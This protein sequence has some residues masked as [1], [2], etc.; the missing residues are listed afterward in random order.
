MADIDSWVVPPS[1]RVCAV[2][3][4]ETWQFIDRLNLSS[5]DF[6]EFIGWLAMIPIDQ[7]VAR[8]AELFEEEPAELADD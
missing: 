4:P 5:D 3:L 6:D 7:Q 2:V 8:V 1:G